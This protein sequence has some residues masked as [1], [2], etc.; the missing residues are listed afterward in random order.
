M[1]NGHMGKAINSTIVARAMQMHEDGVTSSAIAKQLGISESVV[2]N[3]WGNPKYRTVA[4]LAGT[5]ERIRDAIYK[6][7]HDH[8]RVADSLRIPLCDVLEVA[9]I[10]KC[11]LGA[12][13]PKHSIALAKS[14]ED[15][16]ESYR[17]CVESIS[18]AI[19]VCS[20]YL[21]DRLGISPDKARSI[22]LDLWN[23]QP[24]T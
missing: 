24:P 6:Y 8:Q 18:P 9:Q 15:P 10:H 5:Y 13:N 4:R 7:K 23:P 2:R 1:T 21:A 22:L 14:I 19:E 11:R 17:R 20:R 3:F 16:Q 12:P